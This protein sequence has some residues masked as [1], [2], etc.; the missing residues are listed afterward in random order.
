MESV[1]N[2]NFTEEGIC[3]PNGH[4]YIQSLIKDGLALNCHYNVMVFLEKG[5]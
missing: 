2:R 4:F 1:F 5:M 3:S